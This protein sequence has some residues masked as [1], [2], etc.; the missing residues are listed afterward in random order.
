MPKPNDVGVGTALVI[1]RYAST[2]KT[3][4]GSLEVLL[5]LRMGSHAAG[6]WNVPG[7]WMDRADV[8][9]DAAV[10]REA[11]EETGLV[12]SYV[13]PLFWTTEDHADLQVRTVTLWH[14]SRPSEWK[15]EPT[16]MEP[17]KCREWKWFALDALPA[18]L[19]PNTGPAL[20]KAV[21]MM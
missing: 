2:P 5:G 12:I 21:R 20:I 1:L 9:S 3:T 14:V 13:K 11:K 19:F 10:I 18:P 17:K 4:I 6:C 8:S 7:G 15:G 16:V